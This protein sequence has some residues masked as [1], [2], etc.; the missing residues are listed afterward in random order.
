MGFSEL[1]RRFIESEWRQACSSNY[2]SQSDNISARGH[3]KSINVPRRIRT[4]DGI[5]VRISDVIWG[6]VIVRNNSNSGV[7][8]L[9]LRTLKISL[10]IAKYPKGV[11]RRQDVSCISC[12]GSYVVYKPSPSCCEIYVVRKNG[13]K[14]SSKVSFNLIKTI[15]KNSEVGI[16]VEG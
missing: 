3:C 10:E 7:G 12:N 15:K 5:V 8:L 9:D 2:Q 14:F 6:H 1:D 16:T 13:K 11:T 4:P